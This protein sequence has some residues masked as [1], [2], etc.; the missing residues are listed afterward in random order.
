MAAALVQTSEKIST[1][2]PEVAPAEAS[3][4]G[5]RVHVPHWP[6]RLSAPSDDGDTEMGSAESGGIKMRKR[7]GRLR[8][9]HS[10]ILLSV[11]RDVKSVFDLF[12]GPLS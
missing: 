4:A 6:I 5:D 7:E 10:H 3:S 2:D 9:R 12:R 8:D 11:I 1:Y